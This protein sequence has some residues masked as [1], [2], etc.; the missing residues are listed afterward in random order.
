MILHPALG[1]YFC[2]DY[3]FIT[4]ID[5]N[6]AVVIHLGHRRMGRGARGLD[7]LENP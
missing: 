5:S 4:F 2:S 3:Y 7:P 1:K 6:K